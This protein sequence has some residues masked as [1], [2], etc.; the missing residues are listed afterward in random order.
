MTL[1]IA[2]S[3]AMNIVTELKKIINEDLT[4]MDSSCRII[5]CTDETRIGDFHEAT[6]K[7]LEEGLRE[8]IVPDDTTY[9]GTR[10][11]INLALEFEGEVVGV[12]GITGQSTQVSRYGQ[13]IKKMTEILLL[14]EYL[15][16]QKR[17]ERSARNRF[18]Q[19]W[20]MT[21]ELRMSAA[22]VNHGLALGIDVTLPRRVA[23]FALGDLDDGAVSQ[24]VVDKVENTLRRLLK[25]DARDISTSSGTSFVVLMGERD[26]KQA[27]ALASRIRREI[28]ARCGCWLHAG[29]DSATVSGGQIRSGFLRAKKALDAA[30]TRARAEGVVC[31]D[32]ILLEIFVNE[33]TPA[34]RAEFVRRIFRGCTDDQIETDIQMLRVLYS[35]DGS[36]ARASAQ[37]YIH[38][39]T[40]Q[41][42]LNRLTQ[43][44]GFDP[45]RLDHAPLYY[46]AMAF[47][48]NRDPR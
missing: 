39:N 25:D 41:Y 38:K 43:Q 42:K 13:V 45:R 46:L 15:K 18:V 21:D 30:Q 16:E 23:V 37:L 31:Y 10:S 28:Y 8:L 36:L 4:F 9:Q 14:D 34:S 17:M 26:D 11:G 48:E 7:M 29:L 44:T 27:V 47:Y 3:T 5:A 1:H 35:C 2:A 24:Q 22:L 12:V 6:R 20:L 40:L 32:D 33:I 19:E